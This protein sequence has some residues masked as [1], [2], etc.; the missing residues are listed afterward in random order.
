MH[1]VTVKERMVHPTHAISDWAFV[2]DGQQLQGC[3][4]SW[5]L[6][7]GKL[8]QDQHP[9]DFMTR[10]MVDAWAV[11]SDQPFSYKRRR[12]LFSDQCVRIRFRVRVVVDPRSK[13]CW[14]SIAGS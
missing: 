4:L 3:S 10:T 11:P 1:F 5:E 13:V 2:V 9:N 7:L 6:V 14:D 8:L 12:R